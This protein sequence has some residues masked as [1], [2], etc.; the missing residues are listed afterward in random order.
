MKI[1]STYSGHESNISFYVDGKITVVELDKLYGE[2]YLKLDLMSAVE[3]SELIE[4]A[5]DTAGIENDFDI[6]ING[7]YHGRRNG[8]LEYRKMENIIN[9]K[10]MLYGPGHHT[11]HA[12]SAFWQSPFDRAW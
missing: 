2:K 3:Q 6:W 12:H 9:A 7:S 4:L 8:V 1:I 5:M 11:C 10:R